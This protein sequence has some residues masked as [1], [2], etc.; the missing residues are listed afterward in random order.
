MMLCCLN[1]TH[2]VSRKTGPSK[3]IHTLLLAGTYFPKPLITIII[4]RCFSYVV[5]IENVWSKM[6]YFPPFIRKKK[7]KKK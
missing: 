2:Q 3:P 5:K 4:K 7:E 6:F 1:A